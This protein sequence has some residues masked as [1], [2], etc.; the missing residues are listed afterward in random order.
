MEEGGTRRRARLA[1]RQIGMLWSLEGEA[2]PTTVPTGRHLPSKD[3]GLAVPQALVLI[4]LPDLD[5]N[6]GP[7]D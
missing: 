3:K 2:T 6:Q 4:W 5:S 1:A 7:A